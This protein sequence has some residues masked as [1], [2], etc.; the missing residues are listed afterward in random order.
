VGVTHVTA[1]ARDRRSTTAHARR[2][3][4]RHAV[5][6]ATSLLAVLA[7][8]LSLSGRRA[9]DAVPGRSQ[10]AVP[11]INVNALTGSAQLLP[12]LAPAFVDPQ[13]RQIAATQIYQFILS[14]HERGEPLPNVGALLDVRHSAQAEADERPVLTRGN[15]AAIKPFAIVRTPESHR[16]LVVRWGAIYL[17]SV[18]LVV[19]FWS[20]LGIRG[21]YQ[22]LA[23]AHLLTA[24][25]FAALVSRQDPLRDTTLFVR[26]AQLT[27]VGFVCF[28]LVSAVDLRR[29]ARAGFSYLPLV[30]ALGLS[31]AL[32]LFGA[33]PTGSNAK[34]NL[35]PLQPV[36]FIRLLLA[37]FLA[38][39]FA[40]RWDLLREVRGHTVRT[41]QVPGWLNVPRIDYVLPVL[42]G[43]MAALLF[44][45]LQRDLGPALF[46]SCVF[47]LTY[48]LARNRAGLA[49]AGFAVL[50]AG[51]YVGYAL[52]ISSTLTARVAMWRSLWDN[53]ARGGE[54]IAQAI[55]GLAT[56]GLFGTGLGL[57]DTGY[58]PAGYTDLMF[59]AIGEELG[60]V[61]LLAVAA[62]FAI[63]TARGFEAARRAPD[64]YGFFLAIVVTLFLTLPV[65]VMSAGMLGLVP[66]TGVVTPFLSFGGSAMVANFIALGAL[67]AI[68]SH[69]TSVGRVLSDA[70]IVDVV[71][72]F[73]T[74]ITR[75]VTGLSVAAVLILA[76]LFDVQVVR[77][78]MFVARAHA[79]VQADGVRRYQ[80]NER[81]TD[82]LAT[83]PR[84]TV[85]DR[86]GLPLATGDP[87]VARG[88]R[89]A[90]K[91][92]GVEIAG[93]ASSPAKAGHDEPDRCYPLGGAAFH[94]L[95][96]V[97]DARN[98][99][100][101]NTAYIERDAQDRLRGFD[102][103]ATTV[104]LPDASGRPVQTTR[105]DYSELI[106]LLRHR[107]RPSQ[108]DVKAFLS[109]RRDVA[110]TIDAPLQASVA[111]ILS[112]YAARSATGH[113]AA[114]VLNPDT[115]E[116]LA[117]GSY[118]FPSV[119]THPPRGGKDD[120]ETLIDRAR[121]GLYPP[122]STF[123]LVTATAALRQSGAFRDSTFMCSLQGNGR[124][125]AQVAG[126]LVRDDVL[127][128]HPHGRIDMHEGLVQSCNAY[129]A[130][131]AVRIGPQSLFDTANL[132]G[133][134]VSR[135]D[136][137]ARLRTTLPQAGYGQGDVVA[138]PLRMARVAAAIAGGGVLREVAVEKN[139]KTRPGTPLVSPDAAATLGRY[140]RDSVLDGTGR[141]LRGHPWRIAG[142]TGTAEV[143]GAQ[144]HAWF[145]GY[146][147]HGQAERR[148]AF[149]V[150]IENAG[151]GGRAAAPA[152]GEIVSAAA[153]SGL[154]R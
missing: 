47:L 22:L 111:H 116:L 77:A 135:D 76:V 95:G 8:A 78:D 128:E 138:T 86:R 141:A 154:V 132:L 151:Y 97:R 57:G 85:F 90:Y 45:F 40:R 134:S 106:P 75:V 44:F 67:T 96:D 19:L 16:R 102:D 46:L 13:E 49:V 65:L 118:P 17:A 89:D 70:P 12:L 101:T 73:R 152:A 52:N 23:A 58:V 124:V 105:R 108:S 122:G 143:H 54:Q 103:H 137:V 140:L 74:G 51:F 87:A 131:L 99:A 114:V 29:L 125:G 31:A 92:A 129:F 48:A 80:Y 37:L 61:G 79:G 3:D 113:A 4:A 94:L 18:W 130:Q 15:L 53:G 68:H 117:I 1:A 88:V 148:V 33:G 64:D 112:K 145:V 123:K 21:D 119:T 34:V 62:V 43:V 28:A 150:L 115:G 109:R 126:T 50:I 32:I 82:V 72:P 7:I 24:L 56:G 9:A 127:D 38:G 91:K 142:K 11:P 93:C 81:L 35:G 139:T 27:A 63:I 25:G 39:Y 10:G 26:H 147:P 71:A 20:V 2:L 149:A 5:L 36:E 136:S 41:F 121:F 133:I 14:K 59:A 107:Y 66:L 55:W 60:F 30:A 120:V 69:S 153:A 144:S 146:A 83:I 110:L 98:W 6:A 104:R 42:G 84:G 100:A